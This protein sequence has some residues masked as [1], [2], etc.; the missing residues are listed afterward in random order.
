MD[1]IIISIGNELLNGQTLNSNASFI[2]GQLHTIGIPTKKII[3]IGD[4]AEE[5]K[6]SLGEALTQS[7]IVI[8]TGGLGPTHDDI[9]RT[10]LTEYFDDKLVFNEK[11]F[12]K[13]KTKFKKRGLEM[14]P[15]NRNQAMIPAKARLIENPLGTAEGLLFENKGKYVFSLPGIPREMKEMVT[16]S[17]I[18]FLK[19]RSKSGPIQVHFYRTSGIAESKIYEIC[20]NLFKGYDSLEIAF[21]PRFTGVDVRISV[22]GLM[23]D[24]EF[25]IFEKKL[26]QKIG[27]Y[28]YAKGHKEIEEVIGDT[29]R[30]RGLTLAIAESCTGGL[31]Q[32]RITN[33]PGSSDYFLGGITAYSNM[34]KQTLLKVQ[35]STL[36]KYGAV[37]K[38]VAEEMADGARAVFS[39]DMAVSTT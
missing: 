15:V 14:P 19:E 34:S 35:K 16:R 17:I 7:D 6:Q 25:E 29:L 18:P 13:M 3:T 12:R 11:L 31:I 10:V 28:I 1:A 2:S 30:K 20:Q 37:S 4:L 24:P 21:L 23:T 5:I 9:T 38:A 36:E 26:Y 27:K 8:L 32:D 22:I 33:V 39:A